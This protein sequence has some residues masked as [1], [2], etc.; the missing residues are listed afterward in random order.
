MVNSVDYWNGNAK[1]YKLWVEHNDYHEPILKMLIGYVE[2]GW[3]ILD[4]GG[5]SGVL[6]I[7]L[8][9]KECDVVVLEPSASMRNMLRDKVSRRLVST[10]ITIDARRLEETH[11]KDFSNKDLI[12]ACN[13]LHLVSTGFEKAI[14]NVFAA[15]ARHVFVVTEEP[16]NGCSGSAETHSYRLMFSRV[17]D[18]E[19][20]YVYHAK[21]EALEHWSF[22]NSRQPNSKERLDVYSN[23][24]LENG[25]YWLKGKATV[26]FYWWMREGLKK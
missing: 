10:R 20:S 12:V 23:L 5:G 2:S 19:S 26:Y 21:E 18:K 14:K 17:Y 25:H 1:W 16:L 8:T 3:K 22:R 13:S 11:P 15:Q 7:P 6:A 24:S 4:I 9:K